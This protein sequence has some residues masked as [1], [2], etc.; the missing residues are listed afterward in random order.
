MKKDD[1]DLWKQSL[2]E[3]G[4]KKQSFVMQ[5]LRSFTSALQRQVNYAVRITFLKAEIIVMNSK[6]K[7]HQA[8][9]VRVVAS[10]A[11]DSM[12]TRVMT[13]TQSW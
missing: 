10:T 7:W 11:L 13:R 3:H 2:L 8:P 9:N 1:S 4:G 5:T 6:N 12:V